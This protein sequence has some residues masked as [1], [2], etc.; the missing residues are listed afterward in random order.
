L[1]RAN[2]THV[3]G[4]LMVGAKP[5]AASRRKSKNSFLTNETVTANAPEAASASSAK[6]WVQ[7]ACIFAAAVALGVIY[8]GASPL[9]VRP[10][11]ALAVAEAVNA[12]PGGVPAKPQNT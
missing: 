2:A 12:T 1:G 7:A 8:N 3:T 11:Q 6:L 9:G 5:I 4:L 10:P